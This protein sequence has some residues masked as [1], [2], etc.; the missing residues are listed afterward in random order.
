MA[1]DASLVIRKKRDGTVV[2][3]GKLPKQHTFS[4]RWLDR[5]IKS[6]L[7]DVCITVHTSD[8]D[9]DYQ[10]TGYEGSEEGRLNFT[11]LEAKQVKAK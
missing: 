5:E 3:E 6:G 11:G 1:K 7:V 8:G 9:L 2:L 10:M 4:A